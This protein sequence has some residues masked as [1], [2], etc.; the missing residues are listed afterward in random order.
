MFSLT[1][2]DQKDVTK[3]LVEVAKL[4][5]L[6]GKVYDIEIKEHRDKRS[7]DANAYFHLLVHKIARALN[8]GNDEC[9]S[10]LNLEYG[11]PIRIDEDTL[12]AF[13]VPKGAEVSKVVKY[14]KLVKTTYDNGKE[15]DVYIAYKETHTLDKKEMAYL[16]DG[17]VEVAKDLNIETRTPDELAQMKSLWESEE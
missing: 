6:N 10:K 7:K 16:I 14:P 4:S 9:K 2:K 5:N 3:A 8:I 11:S 13:K 15:F 12:F 17:V 1:I